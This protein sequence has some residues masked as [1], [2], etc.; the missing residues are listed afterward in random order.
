L[1]PK[2]VF[3]Q[4]IFEGMK[5]DDHRAAARLQPVGQRC[6][7]EFL[8]VFQLVIDGNP[9]GLKDTSGWVSG[10]RSG[11]MPLG[12]AGL[13]GGNSRDKIGGRPM[14]DIRATRDDGSSNRPAGPLFAK[15]LEQLGQFAFVERSQQFRCGWPSGRIE[16]HIERRAARLA[17]LNA[18]LDAEPAQ[19]VGQLVG[20][21]SQVEQQAVD[22]GDSE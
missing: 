3:D 19:R 7:E 17:L 18:A 6:G 22:L 21:Q 13:R 16:S 1:V 9:Q 14:R 11:V 10:D 20:R 4:S 2:S 12:T 15:T 5:T 8:E